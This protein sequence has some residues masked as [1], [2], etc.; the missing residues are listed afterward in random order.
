M[1]KAG[2]IV[3]LLSAII[4]NMGS[5]VYASEEI[6]RASMGDSTEVYRQAFYAAL[7]TMII[8]SVLWLIIF[9]PKFKSSNEEF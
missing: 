3:F 1:G 6:S 2:K 9:R 7:A 5:L 4:F 8:L